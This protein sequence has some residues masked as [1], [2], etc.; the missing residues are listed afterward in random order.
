M[1]AVQQPLTLVKFPLTPGATKRRRQ[2]EASH[3]VV[4]SCGRA[5]SAVVH[6]ADLVLDV[7]ERFEDFPA[8]KLVAEPGDPAAL[9]AMAAG[10]A[11][12]PLGTDGEWS[13]ENLGR[14]GDRT[15]IYERPQASG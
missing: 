6:V 9:G 11:A 1:S 4:R 10:T 15:Y 2:H 7:R 12:V 3:N 5:L 13:L 14:F 8:R